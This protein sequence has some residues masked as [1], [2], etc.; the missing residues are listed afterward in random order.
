MAELADGIFS[1]AFAELS[2][3]EAWL[4]AIAYT[5]QIY[6]DFSGYSD[7]AIGLGKIFGFDFQENFRY[8]YLSRSI[9]EFWQRW[10]ISLGSWFREYVYIP[11]GGNRKGK[12]RTYINL[13]TVFF[14]TG[15]WHGANWTFIIWGLFH[16]GFQI[17]ERLGLKCF[18]SR[19]NLLSRIYCMLVVILGWVFFRSDTLLNGIR[20]IARMIAPW[21]YGLEN[22]FLLPDSLT[23]RSMVILICAVGG[24]GVFQSLSQRV[25]IIEQKWK[26]SFCELIY[27]C[28]IFAICML[29]LAAGT[30]NPFIY[31]RF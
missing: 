6:Y 19:H 9:H 16:G 10:H 3:A 25:P 15:M 11:L 20:Y 31:F 14:L 24:S 21:R 29:L 1:L 8:P 17:I 12:L 23:I 13:V 18:L 26:Y 28:V 2:T 5:M 30:Y 22:I 7:M 4:G 27:L